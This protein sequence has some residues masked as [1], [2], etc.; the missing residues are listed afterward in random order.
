MSHFG[1]KEWKRGD[2]VKTR[3]GR[4]QKEV[5]QTYGLDQ[6]ILE[7][8]SLVI[9]EKGEYISHETQPIGYLLFALSGEAKVFCDLENGRRFLVSFYQSGGIIGDIEI[10]MGRKEATASVQALTEFSCIMIPTTEKNLAYVRSNP[11]FLAVVAEN[12]AYKLERSTKNGAH[13]ILY[14]L[15]VRLCSYIDVAN[16]DGFFSE[17]LTEVAEVIGTSYRHLLRELNRLVEI[18]ILEKNGKVYRIRNEKE[19]K[20]RSR[21]FYRPVE[22]H[23]LARRPKI[24]A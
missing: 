19:L 12:L 1:K 5:L 11:V 14:P 8:V 6:E 4:E 18:E 17:K 10:M 20:R 3:A 7:G 24:F 23:F 22:E 15:E 9:F 13:I 2:M 16:E 21:D